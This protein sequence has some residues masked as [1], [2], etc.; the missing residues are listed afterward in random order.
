MAM[1][2]AFE[3]DCPYGPGGLLIDDILEVDRDRG[4]VLAR[5]PTSAE[6]PLV[7]AQRVHP[8][9]HPRHVAAGLMIHLTGIMGYAHAY[10][11]EGLRHADGWVGY[12][13]RIK[14]ARFHKLAHVDAPMELEV[15]GPPSRQLGDKRF[16][17]YRFEFRQEGA[18]IYDGEQSA[19]WLKPPGAA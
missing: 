6:L 1:D 7:Q 5:F 2:A 17:H 16:G 13:V 8:V 14:Q 9:K 4:R 3:A 12:G 11:I 10:F 15:V 19:M 18:L